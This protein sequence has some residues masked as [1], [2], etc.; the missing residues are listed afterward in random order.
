MHT[1]PAQIRKLKQKIS[2]VEGREWSVWATPTDI[3]HIVDA[4]RGVPNDVRNVEWARNCKVKGDGTPRWFYFT[5]DIPVW[6]V[7]IPS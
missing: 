1:S 3:L 2:H 5:I 4:W 7:S 6:A